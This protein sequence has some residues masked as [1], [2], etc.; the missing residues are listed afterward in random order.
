M[1]SKLTN[2]ISIAPLITFR[3]LFG[4]LCFLGLL[5]SVGKNEL[6]ERYFNTQFHFKYWGFEW[7]PYPGDNGVVLLYVL[8]AVSALGIAFGAFYR[9]SVLLFALS[10]SYLHTVDSTNYINHY[11]LI[12]IFALYLLFA[13]ANAAFSIDSRMGWVKKRTEIPGFYLLLFLVQIGIVYTFAGIAKINSDWIFSAMPMKIWL[14]QQV[15]FPI[16]GALFGQNWVHFTMSWFAVFYD[17]TIFSWLLWSKSRPYAYMAVLVFHLLTSLLF[18]IGLFPPLMIVACTLFLSAETH[19]KLLSKLGFKPIENNSSAL[20][21]NKIQLLFF[22]VFLIIQTLLPVRHLFFSNENILWTQDYY[23][24]GWRLMLVENEG[25]VTFTVRD[26]YSDRFWV[27]DNSEFLSP[28]Q[29]KRMSVQPEH[30]R[31]FAH[32]LSDVYAKKFLIRNPIVNADV[33]VSLNGRPSKRL[34]DPKVNLA[35]IK[36]SWHQK[37]WILR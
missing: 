27:V 28:Y 16:L 8:A 15:D 37:T 26:K 20:K 33:F 6:A 5:W 35:E 4:L 34:I 22:T 25:F 11:Y 2:P 18:D 17:L 36:D 10:F 21:V 29:I 13:P 3:I 32:Y 30:I 23:R 24:Y 9:L 19:L 14:G 31:Q 7:L 12:W 1:R